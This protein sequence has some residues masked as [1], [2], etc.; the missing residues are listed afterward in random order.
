MLIYFHSIYLS[1]TFKQ[2]LCDDMDMV[3]MSLCFTFSFWTDSSTEV[4][5]GVNTQG[6]ICH[7]FGDS[8]IIITSLSHCAGCHKSVLGVLQ[9]ITLYAVA[10]VTVVA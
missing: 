9:N 3:N 8:T 5:F 4:A 10:Q 7:I 1:L 6:E 2:E